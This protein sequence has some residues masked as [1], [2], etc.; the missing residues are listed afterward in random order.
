MFC[1]TIAGILPTRSEKPAVS[2]TRYVHIHRVVHKASLCGFWR[3]PSLI[4]W[5]AGHDVADAVLG[6]A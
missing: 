6:Q 2:M 3:H 1:R 5:R 4:C